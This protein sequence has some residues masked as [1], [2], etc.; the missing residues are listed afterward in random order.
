MLTCYQEGQ[1]ALVDD[2]IAWVEKEIKHHKGFTEVV[3]HP[4][5]ITRGGII[6]GYKNTLVKLKVE[7]DKLNKYKFKLA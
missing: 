5:S 2:L 6:K 4:A 1:L 3:G 7:R